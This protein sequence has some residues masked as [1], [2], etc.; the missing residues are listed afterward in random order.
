LKKINKKLTLNEEGKNDQEGMSRRSFLVGAGTVLAGTAIGGGL[1]AG[2]EGEPVT[3]TKTVEIPTTKTVSTTVEVPTTITT[4]GPVS[5][6][7]TTKTVS[8][9]GGETT[10]TTTV[11]SDGYSFEIPPNPIPDSQIKQ[12]YTADIIVVGAGTSGM[13]CAK[14]AV[15]NGA[16]V[17]VVTA[18]SFAV[19]RGGSNHGINTKTTI[20]QGISYDV[21]KAF[22]QEMNRSGGRINQ[23]LWYKFYN[24]SPEAM[25]WLVDKMEAAGYTTVIEYAP[26]EPDGLNSAFPGSHCFMGEGVPMAGIGQP[27]VMKLLTNE[28][29]TAGTPIHWKTVAKQLV[30]ENNNTGRVTAVIAQNEA[31]EYV[32]YIGSKAI[33]LATG[34][35]TLD[36]EMVSKYCP[37]VLDLVRDQDTVDYD[38]QFP[39]GMS[40]GIFKGDGHKMALWVGAAWQ[41]NVPNAPMLEGGIGPAAE[42]YGN[43]KG[44]ILNKYGERIC[45]EDMSKTQTCYLQMNQ[46]DR[47][48]Y[49]IWDIDYAEQMKP[50]MPFGSYFGGPET[51][52]EK[53]IAG[54]DS[55]AEKG[56]YAKADTIEELAE[57]LGLDPVTVKATVDR[58]NQLCDNG[59]DADFL[60][61]DDL[62]HSIKNPPFYGQFSA[63]PTIH[64]VTGGIRTNTD[65]QALDESDNVIPGLYMAGTI[66]GDFFA[67]Y[68]SFMPSGINLGALCVTLPYALGKELAKS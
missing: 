24:N 59:F 7:T 65:L 62:L 53:V 33:V 22:K 51:T 35:F 9:T 13:V 43:F 40:G 23:Q 32:K 66:I 16:D 30:R 36:K 8:G 48:I 38:T 54:W 39:P 61:R 68:Y 58:Y 5:T 55:G 12:T 49:A 25:N 29:E 20:A 44:L 37:E 26:E 27:L 31:G 21:R 6:V 4:Q 28:L 42:S 63:K 14:S 45:S 60:K 52:V 41:R 18:S 15:E 47:K 19:S 3:T 1:L 17:I 67:G 50:W 56:T 11:T 64:I 34:D 46:P 10:V 2:C 57:K